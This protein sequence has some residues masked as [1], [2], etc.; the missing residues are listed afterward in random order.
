MPAKKGSPAGQTNDAKD[1]WH[2]A[3]SKE[4]KDARGASEEER[5][6]MKVEASSGLGYHTVSGSQRTKGE[7]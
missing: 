5:C 2:T 7:S 6:W 1:L 3:V 4:G